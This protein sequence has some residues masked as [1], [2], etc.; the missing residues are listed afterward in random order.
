MSK[1]VVE[2]EG[3]VRQLFEIEA[4]SEG[5]ARENYLDG[6]LLFTE[7]LDGDCFNVTEM[8]DE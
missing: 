7:V 2:F 3:T 5:E 1:Y 6:E 4:E 8:S